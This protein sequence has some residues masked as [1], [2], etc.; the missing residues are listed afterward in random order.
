MGVGGRLNRDGVC[1]DPYQQ[2]PLRTCF[3]NKADP[4]QESPL[5]IGAH[6]S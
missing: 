5:L 2:S 1:A 3:I 6:V 4:Y